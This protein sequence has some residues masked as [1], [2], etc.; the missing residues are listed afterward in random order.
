MSNKIYN[1]SLIFPSICQSI[2]NLCDYFSIYYSLRHEEY[3]LFRISLESTPLL[4]L[5]FFP[6]VTYTPLQVLIFGAFRSSVEEEPLEKRI[7]SHSSILA[8]RTRIAGAWG[9]PGRSRCIVD[10]TGQLILPLSS[11][12]TR[13]ADGKVCELKNK[14]L[15]QHHVSSAQA[16]AC[17]PDDHQ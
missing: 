12:P 11:D 10:T 1:C 5:E 15:I 4:S 2:H 7:A 6:V 8:W 14:R 13:G 9:L 16:C 3:H 17:L